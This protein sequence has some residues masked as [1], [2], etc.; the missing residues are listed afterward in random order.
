MSFRKIYFYSQKR[1]LDDVDIRQIGIIHTKQS[2]SK[3]WMQLEQGRG[4][5]VTAISNGSGFS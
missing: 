5:R 3:Q 2:A 1:K 4:R